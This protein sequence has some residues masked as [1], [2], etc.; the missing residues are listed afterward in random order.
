MQWHFNP[1]LEQT[2]AKGR[3]TR[4]LA[5]A[6]I[7]AFVAVTAFAGFATH[8]WIDAARERDVAVAQRNEADGLRL[9]TL[10]T[11]ALDG[12]DAGTAMLL[13]LEALP[14]ANGDG[15]RHYLP[16]AE[17]VLFASSTHL[18]EVAVLTGHDDRVMSAA[19]S[20][21]GK[22][23]ATASWDMTARIWD[24]ETHRQSGARRPCRHGLCIAF[25]PDGRRVVPRRGT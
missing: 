19:F 6:A 20:P 1:R 11:Q 24:A 18:R 5:V 4:L 22:R 2:T 25:S 15:A 8:R 7:A 3:L 9:A 14:D 23:I 10:A 16:H 21:D 13:A 12:G 17:E